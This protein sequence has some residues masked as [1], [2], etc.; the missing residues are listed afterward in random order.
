M[1]TFREFLSEMSVYTAGYEESQFGGFRAQARNRSGKVS[2]L[3]STTY[4]TPEAA[5]G[6]A[7]VYIDAYVTSGGSD[8]IAAGAVSQ[9]QKQNK[10]D[11]YK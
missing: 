2:Y 6:E 4:K 5:K 8:R 10:N 1:K 7:E 3:G 9:Y 11:I